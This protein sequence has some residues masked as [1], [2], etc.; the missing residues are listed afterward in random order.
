M[1]NR[2]ECMSGTFRLYRTLGALFDAQGRRFDPTRR[3]WLS[4][5]TT[6]PSPDASESLD[7]L[8]A[9]SWLQR[10]SGYPVRI[11]IGV[12]GPRE[13]SSEHLSAALE[14]MGAA[15]RA[16]PTRLAKRIPPGA[17]P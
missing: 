3:E 11:P 12:V 8:A 2:D 6:K 14:G 10:E 5:P 17:E 1:C 16:V 13:A 15:L 7:V 4:E 9:V